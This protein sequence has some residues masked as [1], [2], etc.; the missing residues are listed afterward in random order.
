[1]IV[2]GDLQF[3]AIDGGVNNLKNAFFE[4]LAGAVGGGSLPAN[5]GAA[6]GAQGAGRLVYNT[7]DN[8]FYFYDGTS[9]N[10][11][12]A[13][14]GAESVQGELDDTQSS[15]GY[16]GTDGVMLPATLNALANVGVSAGNADLTIS[17]TLVDAL[18]QLDAAITAA[19]NDSDTLAEL[20]DVTITSV[21]SG[22][23]LTFTGTFWE[24]QTADEANLVSTNTTQS[25]SGAKTFSTG[26][27]LTSTL[28]ADAGTE[29]LPSIHL[30]GDTDTGIY[31][32]AVDNID[33]SVAA[34]NVL[35]ISA[36]GAAVDGDV[37]STNG[38]FIG[39]AGTTP[40]YSFAADLDTGLFSSPGGGGEASEMGL[41]KDGETVLGIETSGVIS[42][43]DTGGS[44][45]LTAAAYETAVTD[46]FH[47]P[48]KL[49]VDNAISASAVA[50]INDIND[51]TITGGADSDFL[52]F[53]GTNWVN[54]APATARTSIGLVSGGAG[55]IWVEKTGDAM[56]GDLTMT[57]A[58]VVFDA[59]SGLVVGGD[60]DTL[61]DSPSANRIDISAGG[62]RTLQVTNS[63]VEVATQ[64]QFTAGTAGNPGITWR[65]DTNT[66]MY[67]FGADSIGFSVAGG[68]VFTIEADGTLNVAGTAGYENLVLADDDIPNKRYVD[69]QITAGVGAT[70]LD[71]LTDTTLDSPASTETLQ[72]TSP[73]DGFVVSQDETD[74][75]GA[76]SNG[77]FVG[78]TGY[79]ISDTITLD[80]DASANPGTVITVDNVSSGVVTEFTVTSVSGNPVA[81]SAARSQASTSNLGSGFT[82]TPESN[83]LSAIAATW[84]N[85]DASTARTNLGLVSGGAGD[86]WVKTVG[87][88]MTGTLNMG[89]NPIT[90]VTDPTGAQD[91]ATKAYVDS[92]SAGLD[93]K[94]SV[95]VA[96]D[97]DLD[98]VGNGVWVQAG[99]GVGATLTAG[100]AGTTTLD[101]VLLADGDRVL[102]KDQGTATENGIYVASDT[103]GGTATVLTRATDVDGSPANEVSGG[104]FTFVEQGT[105]N[106][107]SGWVLMGDGNLTVDTDALNW[108]QFSGAGA[109]TAGVGLS[110]TGNTLDVNLG[111]GIVALPADEVGVDLFDS[112]TGAIILTNDGTTRGTATGDQLHLLLNAA[113]G[114]SQGASGLAM[115]NITLNADAGTDETIVGG[116][117]IAL[118]G[119][120]GI[121]TTGTAGVVTFDADV[122]TAQATTAATG[123]GVSS[124]FSTDFTVD[125]NGFVQLNP[126]GVQ[127]SVS[128]TFS[129]ITG[130][131]I[132]LTGVTDT[133]NIDSNTLTVVGTVGT[134]TIDIDLNAVLSDLTDVYDANFT[135]ATFGGESTGTRDRIA[136][137]HLG[138]LVRGGTGG[139]LSPYN[140]NDYVF[141]GRTATTGYTNRGAQMLVWNPY[142]AN[143]TGSDPQEFGAWDVIWSDSIMNASG[144]NSFNEWQANGRIYDTDTQAFINTGSGVT[145]SWGGVEGATAVFARWDTTNNSWRNFT[146]AQMVTMLNTQGGLTGVTATFDL[147]G[148]TGTT[149]TI[150]TGADT[151]T[152]A[153]GT[154]I[155]T[156]A[157]ATDTVTINIDASLDNLSDVG[158]GDITLAAGHALVYDNG[159]SEFRNVPI[160]YVED[161]ASS[162]THTIT[163]N[164]NQQ[165]V[166]VTVV[167]SS[168]DVIIPQ[169]IRMTDAN[170]TTVT[171][172]SAA[173]V[174]VIITG[175]AGV[176]AV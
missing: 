170:T 121:T 17:S 100:A 79:A 1:M 132:V 45:A 117:T 101:G 112:A 84:T 175:V 35:N 15:M 129:P 60:T 85:A 96:T 153:G 154:G 173:Q 118:T 90:N 80:D 103:A 38:Q 159:N 114:L 120:T 104:N 171:L 77:T 111:A 125:G 67:S 44:G 3:F 73:G 29:A 21:G 168:D 144:M 155:A 41:V 174:T 31:Q 70:S 39:D 122:A 140:N 25:I 130:D 7:D 102:V 99:S 127:E 91:A 86:I 13:A 138:Y 18:T 51:V 98:N 65:T 26:V 20:T 147:A 10:E 106:Q 146:P 110:K 75:D 42:H 52:V 166:N 131:D 115:D 55:D 133:L 149:Q 169:N 95:R 108:T 93:P 23:V 136:N 49:Y 157:G 135:T 58:A 47:I 105:A 9:W 16:V 128:F 28:N 123:V 142:R 89:S 36:A 76:G 162:V 126:V 48:N 11:I 152:I 164:L 40:A 145:A 124:F 81:A 163:H 71:L 12:G 165:Y 156:V 43:N 59:S 151:L 109:I 74:Y 176:A 46:D 167:D 143:N 148:D 150:T 4:R 19:A 34:S 97:D 72:Y 94:E 5:G 8:A 116:D 14:S 54:E 32:S 68:N 22:E 160:H 78:G 53:N 61:I 119:G 57:S 63:V 172:S 30:E 37:T 33:F 27:T 66:G 139:A 141:S 62:V 50:S 107:D 2:N 64:A 82:L 56:T 137:A 88:S 134:S 24:N 161:S 113:G 83:N 87:D 158:I 92:V 69:D 6:S